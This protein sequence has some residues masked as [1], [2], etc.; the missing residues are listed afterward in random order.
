MTYQSGIGQQVIKRTTQ[1]SRPHTRI[2]VTCRQVV[3]AYLYD[4]VQEDDLTQ[5]HYLLWRTHGTE[6]MP[7]SAV[8]LALC[9]ST[10]LFFFFFYDGGIG[11]CGEVLCYRFVCH[12]SNEATTDARLVIIA[13]EG[14]GVDPA[15]ELG[16]GSR[17]ISPKP[18]FY[19]VALQYRFHAVHFCW[20]APTPSLAP[21][22]RRCRPELR[23]DRRSIGTTGG[24]G[25]GELRVWCNISSLQF[26][27]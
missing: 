13:D 6:Q 24:I 4:S 22:R 18:P 25:G 12:R 23:R 9:I 1:Q 3:N 5:K 15:V 2:I 11:G 19:L 21:V 17:T 8:F 14:L 10:V 27:M 16:G 20:R 7:R 26:A